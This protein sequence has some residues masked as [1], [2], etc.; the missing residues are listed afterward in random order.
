MR[1]CW[2][3]DESQRPSFYDIVLQVAR[4]IESHCDPEVSG[5]TS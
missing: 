2:N 3:D 1:E 4:V 5:I